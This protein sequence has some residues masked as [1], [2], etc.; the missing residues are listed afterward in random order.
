[1]NAV[2]VISVD[3]VIRQLIEEKLGCSRIVRHLAEWPSDPE[4]FDTPCDLIFID[5]MRMPGCT[6]DALH[7]MLRQFRRHNPWVQVVALAPQE[8]T[9]R[10]VSAVRQGANDYLTYPI[11]D[12]EFELV[13]ETLRRERSKHLELE[14]LRDQFWKADWLEGIYT[15]NPSMQRVLKNVRSVAP[16]IATV[17]LLGQT[18]TGKGWMARL[19]HRHSHRAENAFVSLHC[20]AIPDTLIESELFGHEKGAFTGA[21]RRK[22]GKFE[23]AQNGTIFLDEIGTITPAAQIKLLQVLQD[24]TFNRLGGEVPLKTDAR[25]IAASN[26]D[27]EQMAASGRFREDLL[28]RL[29]IF[30]IHLPPLAKRREDIPHLAEHFLD[31]LN[32]K[33]GRNINGLQAGLIDVLQAYD[34]PGNLRELENILE[35]AY[36]LETGDVL[37]PGSFPELQVCGA[38]SL[39]AMDEDPP[40]PLSRARQIAIDE[41]ERA[42]L[43][44]LLTK[45]G[46]RINASAREAGITS[47]QL[48]RLVTK[49][50]LDRKAFKA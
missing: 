38:K 9:R 42:Y 19:I 15:S 16:T 44:K 13:I 7:H 5:V 48:S 22:I 29:N 33:Y 6:D 34:W 50:G 41:F 26:A 18:G 28:Y 24:G 47:R 45:H 30:P 31:R 32:N 12:A 43:E 20:G 21:E 3:P 10:A 25:I 11:D 35:R 40:I 27:L 17:L 4:V 46:G 8:R 23:L 37:T 36:I 2:L 14:Y 1:M 39:Q 49:H